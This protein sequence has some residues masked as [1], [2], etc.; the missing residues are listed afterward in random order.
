LKIFAAAVE[1]FDFE[2][3]KNTPFV[4]KKYFTKLPPY[5]H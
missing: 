5:K 3:Q 1:A 4:E 2:P